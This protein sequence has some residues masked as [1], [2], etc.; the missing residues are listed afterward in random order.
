MLLKIEVKNNLYTHLYDVDMVMTWIYD[1]KLCMIH[2]ALIKYS[3]YNKLYISVLFLLLVTRTSAI[4][5]INLIKEENV[6]SEKDLGV[7]TWSHQAKAM[8]WVYLKLF[9]FIVFTVYI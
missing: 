7:Y 3:V 5:C 1:V 4:H 8:I 6:L 2:L 9:F